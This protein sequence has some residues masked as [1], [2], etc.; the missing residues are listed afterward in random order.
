MSKIHPEALKIVPPIA[1]VL[2]IISG[3][4]TFIFRDSLTGIIIVWVL[5]LV[6]IFLFTLFFRFPKRPRPQNGRKVYSS[7]DGKVVVIEEVM[8]KEYF[9][10]KRIQLSVFMSITNVHIN[11][12][13]VTGKVIYEKYKPGRFFPA[14]MPKSSALNEHNTFVVETHSGHQIMVRQIAGAVARRIAVYKRCGD[15]VKAGDQLG[16]IRFG[17]RVDLFL[18]LGSEIKVNIGQHVQG[19]RTLLAI[20]PPA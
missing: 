3:V 12:S 4:L 9:G 2:L 11:W 1:L 6:F 5:A 13:P 14:W 8:E 16:F 18:H 7:A 17:S 15:E 10:E 19:S 20:L